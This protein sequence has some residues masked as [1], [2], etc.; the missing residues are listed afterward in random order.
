MLFYYHFQFRKF[1]LEDRHYLHS[2]IVSFETF[3]CFFVQR[4]PFNWRT[5]L[6][7]M[8]GFLGQLGA[9]FGFLICCCPPI[10]LYVGFSWLSMSFVRDIEEELNQLNKSNKFRESHKEFQQRIKQI[11]EFHSEAKQLS[12][13]CDTI[14]QHLTEF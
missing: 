13:N 14:K 7:Y 11:I 2:K 4:L 1:K 3:L 12:R 8:I 10:C 9:F 6:G 5:P